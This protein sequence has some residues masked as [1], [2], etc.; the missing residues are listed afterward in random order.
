MSAQSATQTATRAPTKPLTFSDN[1]K[2]YPGK[3]AEEVLLRDPG[4]IAWLAMHAN[5]QRVNAHC[6]WLAREVDARMQGK[7][8]PICKAAPIEVFS[9]RGDGRV[10]FSIS[11]EHVACERCGRSRY[12]GTTHQLRLSTAIVG[13]KKKGDREA[14]ITL[15]RWACNLPDG[16]LAPEEVLDFLRP[17]D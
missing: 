3:T 16:K 7:L 15:F 1:A 6:R 12:P 10:G 4:H 9:A 11:R 17:E 2:K 14:L 8:C 5:D 13:F